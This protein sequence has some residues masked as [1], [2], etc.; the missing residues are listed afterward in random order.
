MLPHFRLRLTF[1]LLLVVGTTFSTAWALL[2]RAAVR[3]NVVVFVLDDLDAA[4]VAFMP[5]VGSL[6]TA[7][8]MTFSRF[9]A[10]TPLCGPSRATLLRGQYA[11]NHGIE[12]NS[13]TP[14]GWRIF[15]STGMESAT[16]GTLFAEAGYETALIGKYLNGY[17]PS[18]DPTYIP[19]GWDTWVSPIDHAAYAEFDYD[20]NVNGTVRHY[21]HAED[22]YLTDVLATSTQTFL[23]QA[24]AAG[25]PYLLFLAP[26]APH[27]PATPAPRH[28]GRF[29]DAQAPRTPAFN[30]SDITDKS[31]W[32][33]TTS[34]IKAPRIAKLDHNYA[35]RVESLQAVDEMIAEVVHQVEAQGELDSTVFLFLSDN[36]FY[37]GEHRQP[38]GKAAP[39]DGASHVPLIVRGPGIA[40]GSSTGQVALTID[41]LPTL[42]DLAGISAPDFIDGRSLTPLWREPE[43][44][45]RT[46]RLLEGFGQEPAEGGDLDDSV[47]PPFRALRA[48]DLLFMAYATGESERYDVREDPFLLT[49]ISRETSPAVQAALIDRAEALAACAG[50]TC[51]TLEDLP[52]PIP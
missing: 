37:L 23:D 29:A 24:H 39:Y 26:I 49:N 9:F 48:Q 10:T 27:A 51:R 5:A 47:P 32:L 41:I 46:A 34:R 52:L 6:L 13:G 17:A 40:P 50:Q 15:S 1:L 16:M 45:W 14:T 25:D 22:D 30:E 2:G 33:R 44:P 28:A 38:N 20:L 21:G 19:P 12:H 43:G 7:Q 11:H 8:G 42:L 35:L 36:G 4:S 31:A 3:P 18:E